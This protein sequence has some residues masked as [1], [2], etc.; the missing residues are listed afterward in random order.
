MASAQPVNDQIMDQLTVKKASRK[1]RPARTV[2]LPNTSTSILVLDKKP[3]VS[4]VQETTPAVEPHPDHLLELRTING[5]TFKGIIESLKN[6]LIEANLLFNKRGLRMIMLDRKLQA[7]A[8]FLCMDATYFEMYSCIGEQI[9]GV[10]MT[11]LYKII[12]PLR[13]NDILSFVIHKDERNTFRIVMENPEKGTRT[14][15]RVR[16]KHLPEEQWDLKEKFEF[17]FD[18][19]PPEIDSTYLQNICRNLHS[20]EVDVVQISY[21]GDKLLFKGL[22][23]YTESI[24]TI[25]VAPAL[26]EDNGGY[27]GNG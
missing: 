20:F 12:K 3:S 4:R 5:I 27:E 23:M 10:D 1:A 6:V 8:S 17:E 22:G 26:G 16:M 21:T 9:V 2:P 11:Q 18:I 19:P 7:C 15:H 14:E 13:M 25:D 24:Y